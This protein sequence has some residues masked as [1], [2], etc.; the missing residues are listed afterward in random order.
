MQTIDEII[1]AFGGLQPFAKQTGINYS[2]V[3]AFKNRGRI[4][5]E[6]WKTIEAWAKHLGLEGID[7]HSICEIELRKFPEPEIPK[8]VP[9]KK[10]RAIRVDA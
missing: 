7:R 3:V 5:I 1:Q 10:R 9:V 6:H 8:P 4:P 2:T